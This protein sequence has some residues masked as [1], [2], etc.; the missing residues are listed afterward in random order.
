MAVPVPEKIF[1]KRIVVGKPATPDD[2]LT[3]ELLSKAS[4]G[5]NH[6]G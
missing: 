6:S 2:S 4:D 5:P 3:A 1:Y